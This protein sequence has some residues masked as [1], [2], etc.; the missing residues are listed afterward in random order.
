MSAGLRSFCRLDDKL[1]PSFFSL[2]RSP[3]HGLRPYFSIVEDS[4]AGP[5]LFHTAI[6]V[7][8][9]G[10]IFICDNPLDDISPPPIIQA[11]LPSLISKLNSIGIL[12]FSLPCY[13]TYSQFLEIRTWTSLGGLILPT[14]YILSCFLIVFF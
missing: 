14:T 11:N 12:Y 4:N 6:C 1:F 3:F 5:S 9:S 8:R 13:L 7:G 10:S 2:L